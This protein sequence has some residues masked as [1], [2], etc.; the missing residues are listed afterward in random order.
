MM[1]SVEA[2]MQRLSERTTE[3]N[4]YMGM[5]DVLAA[6]IEAL[7]TALRKIVDECWRVFPDEA[8]IIHECEII[9]RTALDK[10][11]AK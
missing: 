3:R 9:A 11:T 10:D 1:T 6:R 2:L 4:Y 5:C 8:G 7:E